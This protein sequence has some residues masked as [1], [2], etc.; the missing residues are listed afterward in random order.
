MNNEINPDF[1][2]SLDGNVTAI[3]QMGNMH[4]RNAI[5][6][7]ERN[8]ARYGVKHGVA[9]P[10]MKAELKRRDEAMSKSIDDW[11]RYYWSSS[12]TDPIRFVTVDPRRVSGVVDYKHVSGKTV[13]DRVKQLEVERA[14]A[15]TRGA[16][17]RASTER[18]LCAIESN[19]VTHTQ[20]TARTEDIWRALND[21]R[22]RLDDAEA[23][24]TKVETPPDLIVFDEPHQLSKAQAKRM[25]TKV[26]KASKAKI[27][28]ARK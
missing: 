17:F 5:A 2:Y 4:L 11:S 9:L 10:A 25:L 15:K 22:D 1:W 27:G 8:D 6:C 7:V 18:R 19:T 24:I 23:R 14:E 12:F 16:S 3:K 20:L 28:K 13:E 26:R 21:L